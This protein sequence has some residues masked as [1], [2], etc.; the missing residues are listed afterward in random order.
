[1]LFVGTKGILFHISPN[2]FTLRWRICKCH[3]N[4]WTDNNRK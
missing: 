3:R 2:C 4:K 1:M